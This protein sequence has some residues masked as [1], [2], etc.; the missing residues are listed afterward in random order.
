MVLAAGGGTRMAP[1]SADRPKVLLP[2]GGR[3]LLSW[4]FDALRD[5]GAREASVIVNHGE[6]ELRSWARTASTL[7]TRIV[8]QPKADG[9][10]GA[11]RIAAGKRPR[12]P[13]FVH[14]GD[15]WVPPKVLASLVREEGSWIGV[16][17]VPDAAAFG[18]VE[19]RRGTLV[20]IHEKSAKPP[21][22]NVF[23]GLARLE[24]DALLRLSSLKKSPRGEYEL[25]DVL[26]QHA[27]DG[28]KI[29]V[30][31][32][33]E[34]FEAGRPWN[35]L[36]IQ[37][38]LLRDAT[39]KGSRV[40]AVIEP[41]ARL[42]G[43]VE[44]GAGTRIRSGAYIEGPVVIGKD[45]KIG[46]NCYIRPTTSI[47]D[48]CHIG[49]SVEVKNSIVMD[50]TNVPHLSYVGDSVLASRVNLGAGT[51]VANLKV[52]PQNVRATLG[53]GSK[54]DTGMRK[55]GTM[56]GPDT[57]IGINCSLNP[58]TVVGANCLVGAGNVLSGWIPSGTKVL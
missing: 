14:Y 22:R 42:M 57:K 19:A 32:I 39:S 41:G 26:N 21:S 12:E 49:A 50:D 20:K 18:S 54:I 34:W 13:F 56:I 10:G 16:H 36:T 27:A 2:V 52:T 47:G 30:V 5:A 35:L 9:T 15:V 51:N 23:A 46:P 24:P 37:Q 8:R 31:K 1:L 38:R 6:P 44:V 58:G 43:H 33:P 25:T 55:L 40:G 48:R 29:R 17:Q 3:P 45:C 4:T 11:V 28:G 7:K 53:D